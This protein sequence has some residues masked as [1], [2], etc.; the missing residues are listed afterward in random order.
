MS[1][2][3]HEPPESPVTQVTHKTTESTE[4]TET[5]ETARAGIGSNESAKTDRTQAMPFTETFVELS[6]GPRAIVDRG[7]S[8]DPLPFLLVHGLASNKHMYDGVG[9]ALAAAGRRSIAIDQRG[10][11]HSAKLDDGY[12]LAT[13][14]ADLVEVL[15]ILSIDRAVVVGQSWGG[16]VVIEM[17]ARYPERLAG[18]VCIDGGFIRLGSKFATWE[19][20]AVTLKPPKLIGTPLA[21]LQGWMRNAHPDWPDSSR[22]GEIASFEVRDDQ[23]IAPWLTFDRHMAILHDLF[24]HDPAAVY[25]LLKLPT[26]MVPAG[27]K[28]SFTDDKAAAVE[29]ALA[30]LPNGSAH[31][32]HEADHDIHAQFPQELTAVLLDFA[33]DLS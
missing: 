33:K 31:W 14:S 8:D 11:G 30:A 25:P 1:N 26:L 9:Q 3:A 27:S 7:P 18:I 13:V 28:A 12:D 20:C 23:T 17:G 16:N 29:Q 10:H 5:T 32:F 24:L 15:T 21:I 4:T 6:S 2:E 22:L 19:D